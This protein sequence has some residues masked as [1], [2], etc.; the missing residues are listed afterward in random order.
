MSINPDEEM[1]AVLELE[2]DLWRN[3]CSRL[4]GMMMPFAL[5]MNQDEMNDLKII[6]QEIS[7][8][9]TL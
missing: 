3:T 9:R 6:L 5:L 2:R 8:E 7:Q 4:I 1:R